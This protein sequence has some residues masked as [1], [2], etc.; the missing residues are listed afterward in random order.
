MNGSLRRQLTG[1]IPE[2]L[3]ETTFR[4][5]WSAQTI[6]MFGDQISSIALPLVAVLALHAGPAQMGVLAALFWLPNLLFGLHAGAWVDRRGHRRA[7]MITADVGR[8]ALL[9][10]IPVCYFLGV[11]TLW[12]LYCVAFS[13]GAFGVL[14][15]VSNP[16]LF[17][18]LVPEGKYVTGNSLIYGSR[19]LSF[20]GGPSVGGVLAQLL[21]APGAV[22]ADALSFIGSAFFLAR[23]RPTEPPTADKGDGSLLA[24]AKFIKNSPIVRSS[25]QSVSVVNFFNFVFNAL[26]VLYASRSLHV[27]PGV[28]GLVLGVG[29]VGSVLGALVTSRLADRFGA[30]RVYT[31]GCLLFTAPIALVPAAAGPRPVILGML[32]AAEF[33][34]GF[35]VM[36][37]DITIGAIFA[38]V[39]PDELRSRVS[40][41]FQ[42]VNYGTRPLGGLAGGL[43]G[44][45][46]GTRTTLW[47][48]AIGGVLGFTLLLPGPLPKFTL[49]KPSEAENFPPAGAAESPAPSTS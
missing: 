19:A 4:R 48:A 6:S 10:S 26:L 18:A 23:I 17:V 13:V 43:L 2:L 33:I 24:G 49:P 14:F 16:T 40:G 38:S 8:A 20:V 29:A 36:T 27:K 34:A 15:T 44:T 41:A 28:L 37:L 12:Q 47:I 30:G 46:I 22:F 39:I 21:T 3:R 32:A 45:L 42:A 9:T 35:G 31:I 5:Y 7:M 1:R 25:L 11:L